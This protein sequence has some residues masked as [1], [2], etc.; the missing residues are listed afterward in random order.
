[1]AKGNNQKSANGPA[2]D[3]EAQ[4]WAITEQAVADA[5]SPTIEQ[6]ARMNLA[7][8]GPRSA[9]CFRADLH[10]KGRFGAISRGLHHQP[11]NM[12]DSGGENRRQDVL[13]KF[14]RCRLSM[15][16]TL[17]FNI[18]AVTPQRN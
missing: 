1:M 13:R 9:D 8:L 7:N 3:F 15:P 17:G 6:L 16:I 12:I 4:I 11:F 18:S 2:L 5:A 10:P 14:G